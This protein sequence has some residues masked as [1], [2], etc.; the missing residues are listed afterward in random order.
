MTSSS[1]PVV[2]LFAGSSTP[3]DPVILQAAQ[4][5]GTALGAQGFDLIYGAGTQGV[6]GA[7]AQ[8]AAKAGSNI[9]AVVF[10]K[11]AHE[12]QIPGATLIP[13]DTEQERFAAFMAAKNLVACLALPGG[14]GSL[15]EAL[16]GLEAAVYEDAAPLILVEAGPYLDG[17][18]HYF[19]HAVE[20]G[21]IRPDRQ[22][23]LKTMAPD[24]DLRQILA[25]PA[26]QAPQPQTGTKKTPA[27]Q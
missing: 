19:A 4:T 13:V 11:Y 2:C 7:V 22:A 8:A 18:K 20:G 5:L 3:K 14:P 10:Q 6:M 24:A 26:S 16:Q 25:A 21:L 17:I 15:R 12:E 9:T 1:R 27:P 23:K